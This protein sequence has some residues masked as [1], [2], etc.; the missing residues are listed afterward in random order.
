MF[1]DFLKF[2][3]TP[4]MTIRTSNWSEV[5][6]IRVAESVLAYPVRDWA[7]IFLTIVRGDAISLISCGKYKISLVSTFLT[8]PFCHISPPS[9]LYKPYLALAI[10]LA[11]NC[12]WFELRTASQFCAK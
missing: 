4:N 1:S 8:S 6:D 3:L 2:V 11:A 10:H 5:V 12:Q 9:R 7:D